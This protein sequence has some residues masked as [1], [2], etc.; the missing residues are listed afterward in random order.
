MSEPQSVYVYKGKKVLV[1]SEKGI[2]EKT[3]PT[4]MV[5]VRL[6]HGLWIGPLEKLSECE[7]VYQHFVIH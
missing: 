3:Y 7:D 5:K 6:A 2:V 4:G 1:H